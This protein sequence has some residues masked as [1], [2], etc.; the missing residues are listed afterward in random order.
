[1]R[2]CGRDRTRADACRRESMYAVRAVGR[3]PRQNEADPLS[4]F[5]LINHY[6]LTHTLPHPTPPHY[7]LLHNVRTRKGRKG[8]RKG[9]SQATPKGQSTVHLE[10]IIPACPPPC[11]NMY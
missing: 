7:P 6:S 2:S 8:T 3:L 10:L 9:R 4:P 11:H 1:V 5:L